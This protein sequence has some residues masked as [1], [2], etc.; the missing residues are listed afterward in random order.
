MFSETK[1][2]KKITVPGMSF[3][4][5]ARLT[6]PTSRKTWPQH[7]AHKSKTKTSKSKS[8]GSLML[9][10]NCP[11]LIDSL[12]LDDLLFGSCS[13][14][15]NQANSACNTITAIICSG[16]K[17]CVKCQNSGQARVSVRHR[18]CD[19]RSGPVAN[20]RS[21]PTQPRAPEIRHLKRD[22]VEGST[23]SSQRT[24]C[25]QLQTEDKQRT[26]LL[27]ARAINDAC[28]VERKQ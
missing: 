14:T 1:E 16:A 19:S 11:F 28:M 23:S 5:N 26:V 22:A 18:R 7:K 9:R 4:R 13:Q 24:S 25:F 20:C 6:P 2:R 17:S 12:L 21:R 8:F 10:T 27:Q 3:A 15:R